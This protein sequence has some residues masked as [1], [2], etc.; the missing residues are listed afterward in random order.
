MSSDDQPNP[1]EASL[2]TARIA[3]IIPAL[4]E[5]DA[6][7]HVLDAIPKWVEQVIVVDN[8]STDGTASVAEAHG[9]QV[10]AEPRRGYGSACLAGLAALQQ[11]T[12]PRPDTPPPPPPTPAPASPAPLAPGGSRGFPL[13]PPTHTNANIIVFLDADF[14]DDPTQMRQ[15]V[16]P[17]VAGEADLVIGARVR[18]RAERGSL[19]IPQRFGNR[20][21]CLLVRLFWR[22]RYSDLG[23]FRAIRARALSALKMTDRTYGWT[24]QMQVRAARHG[25]RICE[26]PVDY[27]RRIGKSKVSGTVRGVIG[28]GV[29][30]LG[31]I[32]A[33]VL[34]RRTLCPRA[35]R[36]IVFTRYP[37]PGAT[38]TRMIPALGPEGAA[39]LQRQMTEH[40]LRRADALR[41]RR[42]AGVEVRF[43]GGD[44]ARLSELFGHRRQ[45]ADQGAGDLGTRMARAFAA[46]FSSGVDA[47][48]TIGSDCPGVTEELLVEAFETLADHD[49]VLGPARDGGYY[50]IGL[51]HCRHELFEAMPW[52]TDQILDR[53]LAVAERLRLSVKLLT[54]LSDVDTPADLP[55][56]HAA[57]R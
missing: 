26:V 2:E 43:A 55:V 24:I 52:G 7:G 40:I 50:L 39:D 41:R 18:G 4:N 8:G 38:K 53:T 27:R 28:A 9:A 54:E 15:L 13:P 47:A 56:W 11:Q 22:Q 42:R 48:V 51:R 6:I 19:T 46:A 36:L 45:Y 16:K 37:Q 34:T 5:Q 49:V 1:N 35:E 44:A 12:R 57:R 29:K 14:S 31:I 17:I 20:L 3:V 23:P 21:A 10:V 33:E 30:I 32:F 25:L